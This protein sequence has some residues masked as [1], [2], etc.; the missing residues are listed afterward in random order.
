MDVHDG[1]PQVVVHVVEGLVPEDTGVVDDDVDAAESV[2]GSLHDGVAVL[3]RELGADRLAAE[4][5]DLVH[6]IVGVDEVVNND[7]GAVLGKGQA[8]RA[9]D[10]GTA[11][12]DEDNATGEV[13]LLALLAGTELDGLLQ[14]GD[15]VVGASGVLGV[16]E[17]GDLVPLLEDGAGGVALIA[18][19][20]LTAGPL[21]PEL[22]DVATADL[23]DGAGLGGVGLVRQDGHE[24]D[25]PLG[26][27]EGQKVRRHDGLGHA[28]GGD[29]GDDVADDVV[30]GALLGEGLCEA[31]HAQLGSRVVG[32]AEVAEQA[33][34]GGGVDDATELLLA[35]VRPGG[36]GALVAALDVDL[37]DEV[38]VGVLD[39]LEAHVAQD[40]GVV[41]QDVNAT[42][43]LDGGVDDLVAIL[44]AVVVGNGL[45]ARGFDLIDDDI[46]GLGDFLRVSF[47]PGEKYEGGRCGERRGK[48]E[49]MLLRDGFAFSLPSD[50]TSSLHSPWTNC[51]LP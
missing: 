22:G 41:D 44:D 12:G 18:L 40:A 3:G 14:E 9:A 16:G 10:T 42:E 43:G 11:S 35:E 37:E 20:E 39:V 38:P 51:P 13:D 24:R 21:P 47:L 4:G 27:H 34:G 45:A 7:R 17:V 46:G 49:M 33:G 26:L 5:L 29:G 28:A 30:L 31:D 15:E 36:A 6:N 8:V 50:R 23:E 32:L 19:E 48:R 2:D 25:D 1:V